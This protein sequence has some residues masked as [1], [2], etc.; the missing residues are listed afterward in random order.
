MT[1]ARSIPR[2]WAGAVFLL[3]AVIF[4]FGCGSEHTNPLPVT[5]YGGAPPE[6]ESAMV[7]LDAKGFLNGELTGAVSVPQYASTYPVSYTGSWTPILAGAKTGWYMMFSDSPG[8]RVDVVATVSRVVFDFWDYEMYQ[9][10]GVV[11]FYLDGA[12]LGSASLVGKNA[13]GQKFM[14]YQVVTGKTTVSTI[15][16][17][18][19][20]GNAVLTGFVLIFPK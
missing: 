18:L 2:L 6:Q 12:F 8:A 13:A 5:S 19:D 3:A 15:T 9:G 14:D 4:L 17:K 16:M 1:F 10:A 11:S 20:S 7:E